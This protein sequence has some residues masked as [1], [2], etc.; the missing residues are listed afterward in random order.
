MVVFGRAAVG[1]VRG[2]ASTDLA[3]D[4]SRD[5][6]STQLRAVSLGILVSG[7]GREPVGVLSS[8]RDLPE[9]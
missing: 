4:P 8:N 2:G 7:W 5:H 1:L 3:A 6:E 9:R